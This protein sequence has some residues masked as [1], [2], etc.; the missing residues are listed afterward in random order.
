MKAERFLVVLRTL[1]LGLGL[2]TVSAAGVAGRPW[3]LDLSGPSWTFEGISSGRGV[4]E[5]FH[6]AGGN[7]ASWSAAEV[8]GDVYT[9]LWRAGRIEDPHFGRN[10]ARAKWVMEREWWY[11]RHFKVPANQRGRKVRLILEGVD[12]ACDVWLNGTHLGRH[13]GM[14]SPIEFEVGPLLVYGEGRE[15]NGLA[16]RLAPPPRDYRAVVGRKFHWEG[17]YWRDLTPLGIWKPVRLLATGGVHLA[18]V[19]P[20]ATLDP[21]GAATVDVQ[22]ALAGATASGGPLRASVVVR[23]ANF[24]GPSHSAEITVPA[25]RGDTT[26]RAAI[27]IPDPQLW[28][29]WDLGRPNLYQ[30]EVTLYNKDGDVL[31]RAVRRF[32]I[33]EFRLERNPGFTAQEVRYPWTP[34]INGVPTFL[35]SAT[36]GGPPDIFYGRNSPEKYR[37]LVALAREANINNLRLF[38]WH[39]TEIDLFYDLCD[40]AGITV[41]QDLLPIASVHIPPDPATRDAIHAEAIAVIKNLRRHPCLTLLEGGEESFF[42][43]HFPEDRAY[44][45]KFLLELEQVVRPYTDLPYVPTSPLNYPPIL[46]ELGIGGPKDSA[47]THAQFYQFGERLIEDEVARWDFAVLPEFGVTAAPNVESI[48]RFIP[49]DELWPPG[50]SWGYRWAD[51]DVFRALNF[52]ILGDERT[53]SLEEFVTATQIAQGTIFQYGVEYMR[54]RKPKSTAVSLCHLMTF[55]PDF[56]WGIVD[57]YQQKKRS[58]DY[59]Q[60]AFQPLL[61]SLQHDRRRWSPGERFV[62][63][64]WVVNDYAC[65]YASAAV[66]ISL[67]DARGREV[68]RDR[69]SVATIAPSSSAAVAEIDH[70]VPGARGDTFRVA[71]VLRAADGTELSRNRYDLLVGDQAQARV[72][73]ARRAQEMRARRDAYGYYNYHRYYPDLVGENR[74]ERSGDAPPRA[75]GFPPPPP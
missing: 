30:A 35:R 6:L 17:D 4:E 5:R 72:E 31:D 11:V 62:G 57:A 24:D 75:A 71:L 68:W 52:Q 18:D 8:P 58:F 39:P 59:V 44:T 65:A 61:V 15:G 41:W 19:Y 67:A 60:R 51:L 56:K 49:A 40:E 7:T 3:S 14:F 20:R 53:G 48:R 42:A 55:A 28:W 23:G 36:W 2:G 50:P 34:I 37:R 70:P 73:C 21:G 38:G 45:A 29:P 22:L 46:R 26:V 13:E 47:H 64:V 16:I 33:R 25:S 69:R 32:G 10:G 63:R 9:D 66:E 1:M 43:K 54:R 12:Y 27:R 74:F